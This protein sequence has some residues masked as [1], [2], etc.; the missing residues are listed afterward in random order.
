MLRAEGIATNFPSGKSLTRQRPR[1]VEEKVTRRFESEKLNRALVFRGRIVK[2][3][4]TIV[5]FP[6]GRRQGLGRMEFDG[7]NCAFLNATVPVS[8]RF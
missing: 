1:K 2:E 3:G 5:I 4:N 8:W 6:A 7:K